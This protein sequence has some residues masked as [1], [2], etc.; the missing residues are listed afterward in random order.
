VGKWGIWPR[1]GCRARDEGDWRHGF[2]LGL[3][4]AIIWACFLLVESSDRKKTW[5]VIHS[6]SPGMR[7]FFILKKYIQ[8]LS[9]FSKT[10]LIRGQVIISILKRELFIQS[11]KCNSKSLTSQLDI[12]LILAK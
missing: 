4:V 1:G 9:K 8:S 12:H 7:N 3:D 6:C 10:N 5:A 2:G 11:S